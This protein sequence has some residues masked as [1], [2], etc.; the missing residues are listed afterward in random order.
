MSKKKARKRI[1]RINRRPFAVYVVRAVI[2]GK[3]VL[4]RIT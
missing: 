1:A 4:E 2:N 3:P